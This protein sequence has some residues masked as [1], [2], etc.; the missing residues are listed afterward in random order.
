M[1][2][3]AWEQIMLG[4]LP[5]PVL[6]QS[7]EQLSCHWHITIS[8]TFALA[9]MDNHPFAVHVAHLEKGC[10]GAANARSIEN[11]EDGAMHQVWSSLDHAADFFRTQHNRQFSGC[12]GKDQIIVGDVAPLQCL[13]VEKTQSRHASFDRARGKLLIA[14]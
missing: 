6:T 4:P 1:P 9:N 3:R 2:F 13:L 5:S 14:E 10:L 12:L 11:H 8:G 7:F